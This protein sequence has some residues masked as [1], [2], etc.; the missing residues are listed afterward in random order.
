MDRT[1]A[2]LRR[3]LAALPA[4]GYDLGILTSERME[5][6]EALPAARLLHMLRYLKFR[7][8]HG[9]HI[10]LR[11]T[12][13]SAYTL[14][15]DLS[16]ATLARLPADGFAPAAVVETSPGN[17]QAWLRHNATMSKELGTI[18]A[19]LLAQR[20]GTDLSAADWRRFGRVPGFTNR[21]PQHRD[22]H[23]LYPFA[24]LRIATGES[25]AAAEQF[26]K[27]MLALHAKAEQE[28]SASR[29]FLA[30]HRPRS[31]TS[32]S[33]SRFRTA[34][35]FQGRPAAADMAFCMAALSSGWTVPDIAAALGCS[36]L[37]RDTNQARQAAY[38]GRTLAKALRW[39]A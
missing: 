7:N 2:T 33:L 38:I 3:F 6:M 12:G 36:Y 34:L 16:P 13:E 28:R 1:E 19:R 30:A 27:E 17:L 29:F 31:L 23:G 25:F 26:R 39:L 8:T 20:F 24:R 5:R 21:K 22:E 11:P 9:A 32:I 10:F 15:D 35:R 18:A 14:L 37:S 4:T